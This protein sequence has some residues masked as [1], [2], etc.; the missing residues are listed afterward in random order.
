MAR[1]RRDWL[2]AIPS[3]QFCLVYH[4]HWPACGMTNIAMSINESA[5]CACACACA[6]GHIRANDR[7]AKW[8]NESPAQS[9]MSE[10]CIGHRTSGIQWR[11]GAVSQ[12]ICLCVWTEVLSADGGVS[13]GH[14]CQGV[15]TGLLNFRNCKHN[16]DNSIR[17]TTGTADDRK[18]VQNAKLR[19]Q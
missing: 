14:W 8:L 3:V 1:N 5:P 2:P 15:V 18:W 10:S 4:T 13:P 17:G 9:W 11:A 19:G 7:S 16:G 12:F 6:W